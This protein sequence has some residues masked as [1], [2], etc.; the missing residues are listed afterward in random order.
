MHL[1]HSHRSVTSQQACGLY[2]RT[3]SSSRTFPHSRRKPCITLSLPSEHFIWRD[4]CNKDPSE[5][6]ILHLA[7]FQFYPYH[8]MCQFLI[9]VSE[10]MLYTRTIYVSLFILWWPFGLILLCFVNRTAE[11]IPVYLFEYLLS[12]HLTVHQRVE[13]PI[14]Q[15]LYI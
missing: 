12:I 10:K 1:I 4:L 7:C 11:F 3:F 15:S 14:L 5:S 9:F 6:G 8:T 2:L 13:F